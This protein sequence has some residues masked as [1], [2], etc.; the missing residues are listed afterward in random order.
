MLT[1]SKKLVEAQVA[2]A[3]AEAELEYLRLTAEEHRQAHERVMDEKMSLA[4]RLSIA[5]SA[6]DEKMLTL[7]GA[8]ERERKL[9]LDLAVYKERLDLVVNHG[10]GGPEPTGERKFLSEAEED[11]EHAVAAG[12]LSKEELEKALEQAGLSNSD[13]TFDFQA[14]RLP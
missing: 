9:E 14:H 12:L 10:I 2:L 4:H 11:L 13:I 6:I 7:A 1:R 5:E 3:R 8:L